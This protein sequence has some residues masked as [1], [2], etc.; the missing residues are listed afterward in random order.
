MNKLA[1][2]VITSIVFILLSITASFAQS[3]DLD[4]GK[5]EIGGQ[6]VLLNAKTRNTERTL[7][8][9][10]GGRLAY[11]LYDFLSL[12]AE[13]NYFP[14]DISSPLGSPDSRLVKPD[15]Q[16]LF[17]IK[18][19]KR[20]D[21]IGV[22]GKLRPGFVRFSPL[23]DCPNNDVASCETVE[24]TA[25]TLD[26]GIVLEGYVSSRAFVRFDVGAVTLDYPSTTF[27][28]PPEPGDPP[29]IPLFITRP[30]FSRLNPQFSL[31]AGF[32]F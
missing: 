27:F 6:L 17:G 21:K 10:F 4:E 15:F 22:F 25:R 20:M 8:Q 2:S 23:D 9:G 16:G 28:R 26:F 31:G 18:V 30:G 5:F 12:E 19:G 7:L 29:G 14:K 11:N 3:S 24:K 32:R 1:H 13:L